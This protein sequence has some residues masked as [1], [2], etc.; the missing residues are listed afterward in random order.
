VH[1]VIGA[2]R[3]PAP[4]PRAALLEAILLQVA[5]SRL[6]DATQATHPPDT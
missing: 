1:P 3:D 2:R 4:F 5:E 6:R